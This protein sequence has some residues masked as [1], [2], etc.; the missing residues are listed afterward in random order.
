MGKKRLRGPQRK[1]NLCIRFA[2][3]NNLK[4][5]Q[6]KVIEEKLHEN[7]NAAEC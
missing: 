2:L 3:K 5:N 1:T 6:D 7:S 4:Y